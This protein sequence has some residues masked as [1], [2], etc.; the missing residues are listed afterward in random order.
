[1]KQSQYHLHKE[2]FQVN[3]E[4]ANHKKEQPKNTK[5]HLLE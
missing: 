2:L 1:M 5:R 3:E 4:S